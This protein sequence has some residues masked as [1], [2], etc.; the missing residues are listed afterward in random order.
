MTGMFRGLLTA[1]AGWQRMTEAQRNLLGIF[2]N[3]VFMNQKKQIGAIVVRRSSM[4]DFALSADAMEYMKREERT[5]NILDSYIVLADFHGEKM[6]AYELARA[7]YHRLPR[8]ISGGRF[9]PYW[10][11]DQNF[12]VVTAPAYDPAH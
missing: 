10:W 2:P 12:Q 4:G 8:P 9:G 7:V 5:G 3:H 1:T 11:L 6:Y